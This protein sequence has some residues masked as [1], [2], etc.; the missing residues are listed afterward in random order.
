MGN[1]HTLATY[2]INAVC[3]HLGC[4]ASWNA[5]ENKFIYPCHGS[6]YNS[7]GQV[8]R[9]LVSLSLAL[10]HACIDDGKVV[11]VPWVETDFRTGEDPWWA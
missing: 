8:I 11:S 1:D 10:T 6:Q 5:T 9:G 2:G 3:T 7:Q 4:V